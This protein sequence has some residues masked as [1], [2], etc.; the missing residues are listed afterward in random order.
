VY[1][2][3][4][5]TAIALLAY[6]VEEMEDSFPIHCQDSIFEPLSMNHT[7]WFLGGLDTSNIAYRYTWTGSNYYRHQRIGHPFYPC[8]QLRAS[9]VDL[10]QHLTAIMQYGIIDTVRILDSTT[11]DLIL[12]N[13]FVP[14]PG[15]IMGLTWYYSYFYDGRRIWNHG[16]GMT[17]VSTIY[18]FCPEE[19]SAVVV[20]M[21]RGSSSTVT[22][23]IA[24]ALFD[25]AEQYGIVEEISKPVEI[26]S[27]GATIFSGPLLLPEGRK[28]RVF[29]ITGSVVEP[30]KIQPGIH[31]IEIDGKISQKIIKIR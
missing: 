8:F 19:S 23:P 3:Y 13:Q 18:G 28:C 22:H 14:Y 6:L 2:D 15:L 12:S 7:S 27:S 10:A 29:D 25:Y 17:G 4:C 11:V 1:Y 31:F 21:N 24:D 16:G 26:R 30:D 9:M 20:L 5:N